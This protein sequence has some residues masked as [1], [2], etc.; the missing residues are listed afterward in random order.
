MEIKD[1]RQIHPLFRPTM[2]DNTNDCVQL[3]NALK[4][5]VKHPNIEKHYSVMNSHFFPKINCFVP[6][7]R[8]NN[9]TF[10]PAKIQLNMNTFSYNIGDKY[11]IKYNSLDKKVVMN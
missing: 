6:L 4:Q 5:S 3:I 11:I 9:D 8:L 2:I 1:F 10:I 7:L